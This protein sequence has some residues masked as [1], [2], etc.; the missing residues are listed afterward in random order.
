MTWVQLGRHRN[1]ILLANIKHFWDPLCSLID[2]MRKLEYIRGDLN[3]DLLVADNV[4]DIL[5]LL[6]KAAEAVPEEEKE[7]PAVI[8]DRL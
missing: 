1:P 3:F 5:P 7:M 4:D 6:Q 8:A 2:H